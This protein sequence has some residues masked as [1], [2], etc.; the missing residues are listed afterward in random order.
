[1]YRNVYA[2]DLHIR[3][4]LFIYVVCVHACVCESVLCVKKYDDDDDNDDAY[5]S[6]FS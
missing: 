5:I 4:S 2:C 6:Q 3:I 1:M